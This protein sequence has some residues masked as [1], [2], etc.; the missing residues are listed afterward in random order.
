MLLRLCQLKSPV[1]ILLLSLGSCSFWKKSID[2]HELMTNYSSQCFNTT[3]EHSLIVREGKPVH[4]LFYDVEPDFKRENGLSNIIIT[5]PA[6]SRHAYHVDLNSGQRHYDHT[7]CPQKDVWHEQSGA[8]DRPPF[9]IGYMP[10]ALDQLG[11]PQK[12]IVFGDAEMPNDLLDYNYFRVRIVAAYVEQVCPEGNCVGRDNWLSRLVFVAVD[13][14]DKNMSKVSNKEDFA[15]KF[16]WK[17]M[18]G[19]LE[20]IDGRNSIGS[21]GFPAIRVKSLINFEEAY[22]Y[23]KKRS[24]YFT[25]AELKKIQT[26]CHTLYNR[27]WT[28]VGE[29]RVED[30]PAKTDAE[31]KTKLALRSELRKKKKPVGFA[32]RL[33]EFTKK[34]HSEVATCER[35]VYHGNINHNSDKFWFLSYMGM[36]YRLHK[37][38]QVFDCHKKHW[39]KNT[40]DQAGNP[41]YDINKGMEFCEDR[42]IDVAMDYLSNFLKTLNSSQPPNYRFIDYDTHVFGTH[43]KLYSWTKTKTNK[44]ECSDDPNVQIQKALPI[45]PEDT[46]WKKRDVRD[47]ESQL[48]IIY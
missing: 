8:F 22:D 9:A 34:Y 47:A 46:T 29:E 18:S 43:R 37:E 1:L 13:P 4:H 5:T 16:D 24:I 23:F 2:D 7:Y 42:D 33:R 10:R 44:F 26:G 15:Q 21:N 35:F 11:E 38:G 20:N 25:E 12:V 28:D 32:A 45:F 19:Y 6:Y 3:P 30:K 48:K 40:L 27:L 31:L 41:V 39:K 14:H 36:F 17:K